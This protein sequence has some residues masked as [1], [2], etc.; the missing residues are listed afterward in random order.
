MRIAVSHTSLKIGA[1][2]ENN[3]KITNAIADAKTQ[4]ADVIIFPELSIGSPAAKDL[5]KNNAFLKQC[6]NSF[7]L[8][9]QYCHGITCIIGA[10]MSPSEKKTS[11][12]YNTI[13][14][15]SDGEVVAIHQKK[16]LSSQD[17]SDEH[18]YF[19]SGTETTDLKIKKQTIRLSFEE[20]IL[21]QI[22]TDKKSANGKTDLLICLG[23]SPFSYE[24]AKKRKKALCNA[25]FSLGTPL[26]YVNHLGAYTDLLYDGEILSVDKEGKIEETLPRFKE[27]L[28]FFEFNENKIIP[29]SLD[30]Q[31]VT[32][33]NKIVQI[34][35]ALIF[36]LR[37]YFRQNN[38]AK[39]VLGLSGGLDS[40]VVAAL[41]CEALGAE[42]VL[43]ALMPSDYS[44]SHSIKDAEDL[45]KNTGCRSLI[46]PIK[47]VFE[48]YNS[49][50][51]S[52]FDGYEIDV[53]EENLQ[54]RIRGVLLMAL[55]NKLGYILLNTSNKSESAVGYG[56]LYGDMAGALSVIGDVYKSEA[57][58]LAR[59]INK[60]KEII[61][62]N[63]IVKPPSAELRPDQKDSDSLPPY[64]LLDNILYHLIELEKSTEWLLEQGYEKSMVMRVSHLLASSEYKRKQ[65][66]PVLRVSAKAFGQGRKLPLTGINIF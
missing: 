60:E 5:W 8:I 65:A 14:C 62:Y 63:T 9:Q 40:A 15:I 49:I 42:N 36:G 33:S 45:V 29:K 16:A 51:A 25:A 31:P 18:R 57:Y 24:Q 43:C 37:E 21:H 66:A 53:T 44:P 50:L 41:A 20:D 12:L 58:E 64:E 19:T 13:V 22:S 17:V 2:D 59:Y 47:N 1:F 39:A 32:H 23:A 7:Q 28:S 52:P 54:A 26:L 46:L 56:T 6:E 61:P 38:F 35:Q 3:Q 34:H 30:E 10:P 27:K 48:A 4:K 55:S 11:L